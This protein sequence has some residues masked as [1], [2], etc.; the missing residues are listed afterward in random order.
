MSLKLKV[1]GRA[2]EV[3]QVEDNPADTILLK[4]I[5]KK[6][7]ALSYLRQEGRYLGAPRPDVVLL[8]LGLPGKNGLTILTEIRQD[9]AFRDIPVLIFTSSESFLDMS[10]AQRCNATQYLVKPDNLEQ[11]DGL[12]GFLQGYWIKT[13]H[14]RL[15]V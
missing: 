6:A 12:L 3:L 11:F 2:L 13:F 7:E 15:P 8:D 10:W 5:L 1:K 4:Q 14:Y 9:P